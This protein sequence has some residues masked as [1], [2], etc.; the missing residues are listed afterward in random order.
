MKHHL[1]IIGVAMALLAGIPAR[2]EIKIIVDRNDNDLAGPEFRFKNV[3]M[4]SVNNAATGAKFVIVSGAVDVN[5]GGLDALNDGKLPTE[6]DEP[7]ANF[8][9][10]AGTHGGRLL[11]DLGSVRDIK[12]VNTYSWH[13][14]A[15][16]PQ[17][18]KLYASDGTSGG[19]DA[20]P[21][22]EIDPEKYGWKL[23]ASVNTKPKGED[24]GGQYGVSICDTSGWLGKYRYL[25][26]DISST[27]NR[28]NFGNTF[29]SEIDVI[30]KGDVAGAGTTA[31]TNTLAAPEA[32][33]R[34]IATNAEGKT[35][36]TI[37]VDTTQAPDMAAWGRHAGELCA[38][39]Y[40]KICQWLESEDFTPPKTVR[41]RI[42]DGRGVAGTSGATITFNANYFRRHSSDYGAAIHELTHVVQAY[43]SFRGSNANPG[44]VVEGMADYIRFS[45]FEP[46]APRPRFRPDRDKYDSGYRVTAFFLEWIEQNYDKQFVKEVNAA[47]RAGKFQMELFKQHTGK[48]ADELWQEYSNWL[49]QKPAAVP[50]K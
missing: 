29:Y 5:S 40:P 16:G 22:Q 47:C 6:E 31:A 9:F 20:K 42:R 17:V 41:L 1:I 12:E 24:A 14:G 30:G 18:Y 10:D 4:P 37:T 49:A 43:P 19:F 32:S 7:D 35:L 48:T 2:A 13:P 3:P 38:E 44:W 46:E 39:W 8:F 36:A 34:G 21:P 23:V 15:R 25:L 50:G 11:A 28:D 45:K 33:W 26:F 27:E